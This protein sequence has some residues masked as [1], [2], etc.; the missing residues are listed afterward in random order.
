MEYDG[1]WKDGSEMVKELT[2][3][4]MVINMWVNG[5]M[6]QHMVDELTHGQVVKNISGELKDGTAHG[7]GTY[8]WTDGDK[9]VGEWIG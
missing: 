9:Y 6:A 5:K 7:Q 2:Y 1:E 3:P 4:Q 8:T